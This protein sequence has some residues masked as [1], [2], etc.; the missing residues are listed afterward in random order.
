MLG[1]TRWRNGQVLHGGCMA[2]TKDTFDKIGYFEDTLPCHVD[3]EYSQRAMA[4]GINIGYTPHYC[5]IHLGESQPTMSPP[6]KQQSEMQSSIV[7]QKLELNRGFVHSKWESVA[8][9]VAKAASGGMIV[10]VS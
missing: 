2:I 6:V 7:A 4:A 9:K 3:W 8:S 10:N 1:S 5:V